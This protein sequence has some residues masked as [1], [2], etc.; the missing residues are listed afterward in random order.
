MEPDSSSFNLIKTKIAVT[1]NY[2]SDLPN[3]FASATVDK[4]EVKAPKIYWFYTEHSPMRL[5]RYFIEIT[6]LKSF[7]SVHLVRHGVFASHAVT[8]N[9]ED[10]REKRGADASTTIDRN[11]PVVHMIETNAQELVAIS[12]KRLCY[13]S[14]K[15]TTGLWK[16]VC[17]EIQRV[18]PDLYPYLVPEC[19]Y[20]GHICPEKQICKPGLENVV[21]AYP[22]YPLNP[23]AR[24]KQGIVIKPVRPSRH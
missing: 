8:S 12:R 17:K 21:S 9:R 23:L 3:H 13:K 24:T 4:Q 1:K 6:G 16:K 10:L 14:H 20:R 18:E 11:S 22:D 15:E 2:R 5:F 19:V 7:I